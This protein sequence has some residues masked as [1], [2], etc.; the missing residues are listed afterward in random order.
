[1]DQKYVETVRACKI[2]LRNLKN[3][4]SHMTFGQRAELE[5]LVMKLQDQI[6][7]FL[8]ADEKDNGLWVGEE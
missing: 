6:G 1:M 3:L 7:F 8:E 4:D 2:L 5:R